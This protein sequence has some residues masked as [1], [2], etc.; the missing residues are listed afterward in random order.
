MMM[1]LEPL[2]HVT[3][4]AMD[5]FD[6]DQYVWAF[7]LILLV[8]FLAEKIAPTRSEK[9]LATRLADRLKAAFQKL[10]HCNQDGVVE[11]TRSHRPV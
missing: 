11:G 3:D 1:K 7:Q 2:G 6:F 8:T 5:V 10:R 9:V 4:I